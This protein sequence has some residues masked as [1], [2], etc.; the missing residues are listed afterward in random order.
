[1]NQHEIILP[2][3]AV[4]E[5]YEQDAVTI[6]VEPPQEIPAPSWASW[7]GGAIAL[8]VSS[9]KRVAEGGKIMLKVTI[10]DTLASSGAMPKVFRVKTTKV[11]P[12]TVSFS[13]K[14]TPAE[15]RYDRPTVTQTGSLPQSS[16]QAVELPRCTKPIRVRP[17]THRMIRAIAT[18]TGM[19]IAEV[20]D[21]AIA[22]YQ[23]G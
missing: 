16:R 7:V 15:N 22:A 6:L 19:E 18:Q 23:P 10:G 21:K 5:Y 1:M 9:V 3:A 13:V 17:D 8:P 2:A 4:E 11:M 14:V 20:I 12:D